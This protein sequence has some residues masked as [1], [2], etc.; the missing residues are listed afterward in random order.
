MEKENGRIILNYPGKSKQDVTLFPYL[1]T[2]VLT[3]KSVIDNHMPTVMNILHGLQKSI[4]YLLEEDI[5]KEHIDIIHEKLLQINRNYYFEEYRIAEDY[6][7]FIRKIFKFIAMEDLYPKNQ[8]LDLNKMRIAYQNAG[9]TWQKYDT[10]TTKI[11]KI[12]EYFHFVTSLFLQLNSEDNYQ[13]LKKDLIKVLINDCIDREI[14]SYVFCTYAKNIASS[15]FFLKAIGILIC[16]VCIGTT[17][18]LAIL[19]NFSQLHVVSVVLSF[20]QMFITY[21]I[22][23]NNKRDFKLSYKNIVLFLPTLING[24]LIVFSII[25]K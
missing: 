6:Y 14:L 15:S 22:Q 23:N 21:N 5:A 16:I 2:A 8:E 7:A 3:R 17:I 1:F 24:F 4:N 12:D 25:W 13:R 20:I 9:S 19:W 18:V 11:P 10:L